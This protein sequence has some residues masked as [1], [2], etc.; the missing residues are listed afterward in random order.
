M[1]QL[2]QY[3]AG[4]ALAIA[5]L[6]SGCGNKPMAVP[7]SAQMMTEGNGDRITFRAAEFGR[8]YVSNDS[9]GKILYQG[10]VRKGDAVEVNPK[11]DRIQIDGRTVTETSLRDGDQYK[12]YFEPMDRGRVARYRVVEREERVR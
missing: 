3:A 2:R 5:T 1:L 9:T 7:S 4:A 11:D 8:V 6:V 12:I 10:D